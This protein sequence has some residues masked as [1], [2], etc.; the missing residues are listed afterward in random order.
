MFLGSL[1][2]LLVKDRSQQ[3]LIT[4]VQ[5]SSRGKNYDLVARPLRYQKGQGP[6]D[7]T[8]PKTGGW[9]PGEAL[10]KDTPRVLPRTLRRRRTLGKKT[11]FYYIIG[12]L[13]ALS[14]YLSVPK[15]G[16]GSQGKQSPFATR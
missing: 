14:L 12:F 6:V 15:G 9:V 7:L 4:E 10:D 5:R 1:T 8:R 11:Y 2:D 13:D 3:R 16:T